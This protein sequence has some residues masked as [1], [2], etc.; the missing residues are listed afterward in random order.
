LTYP[1]ISLK[2]GR[3]CAESGNIGE[4]KQVNRIFGVLFI[5]SN[6]AIIACGRGPNSDI[7][8]PPGGSYV[9]WKPAAQ[10]K[11]GQHLQ[12]LKSGEILVYTW[13]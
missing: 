9:G 3:I 1:E 4:N 2:T 11:P 8:P 12:M 5:I 7:A 6:G 10:I 13:K